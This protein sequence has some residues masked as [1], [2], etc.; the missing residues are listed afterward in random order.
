MSKEEFKPFIPAESN[1]AEFTIK[2]VL[3]GCVAGIIFGAATVYL[4]L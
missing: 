3:L 1:I 4:A 2:S